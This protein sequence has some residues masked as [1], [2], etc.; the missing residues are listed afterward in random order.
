M[1][2]SLI[3]LGGPQLLLF[4]AQIGKARMQTWNAKRRYEYCGRP[5]RFICD[6]SADIESFAHSKIRSQ[7]DG[8]IAFGNVM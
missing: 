7:T 8:A 3:K 1:R 2:K 5:K 6:L 4:F